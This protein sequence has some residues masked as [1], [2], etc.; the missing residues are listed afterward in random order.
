VN[1][2]V[3]LTF[4][5]IGL[6]VAVAILAARYGR[7]GFGWFALSMLLSPLLGVALVLALGRRAGP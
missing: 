2:V 5:W 7:S 1:E 3:T 4:F 6:C